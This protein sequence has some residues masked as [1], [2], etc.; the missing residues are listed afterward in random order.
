MNNMFDLV[1]EAQETNKHS[2]V[3]DDNNVEDVYNKH[4]VVF[5]E[6]KP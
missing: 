2:D 1:N 6:G 5:K 3:D 4:K